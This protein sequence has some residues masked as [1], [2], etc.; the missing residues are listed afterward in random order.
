MAT[1]DTKKSYKIYL[2][3]PYTSYAT[4]VEAQARIE[5][6]RFQKVT[7]LAARL[8]HHG[9]IVYS[10]ITHTHP[11]CVMCPDMLGKDWKA[12]ERV[13]KSFLEWCDL[14]YVYCLPGWETSRGVTAEIAYAQQ[15]D[16]PIVYVVDT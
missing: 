10:P 12:W 3:C 14:L 11:M 6:Y 5:H 8:M 16:K 1:T 9:L 4:S 15:L 2:A 7:L 13:D